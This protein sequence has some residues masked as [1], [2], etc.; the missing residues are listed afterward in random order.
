MRCAI[1]PSYSRNSDT[2]SATQT[3]SSARRGG[4]INIPT[5]NPGAA[6]VDA[7]CD[8]SSVT[9]AN[10]R[11]KWQS[12]MSRRHRGTIY[13]L[14]I[15]CATSA[16]A[17]AS[18]VDACHLCMRN[19]HKTEQH[20]RRTNGSALQPN[21]NWHTSSPLRPRPHHFENKKRRGNSARASRPGERP[22]AP[23]CGIHRSVN[24]PLERRTHVAN[25]MFRP[26]N[27]SSC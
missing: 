2:P 16:I 24:V 1:R 20:Q 5:M 19:T 15:G 23:R 11:A 22:F 14:P 7:N 6:I 18:A 13:P 26:P 21:I 3:N 9:D 25:P 8:T 4:Q 27:Q 10:A 17:I 12:A